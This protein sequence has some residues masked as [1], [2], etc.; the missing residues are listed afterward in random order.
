LEEFN[1]HYISPELQSPFDHASLSVSVTIKEEHI[2][3]RKQTI[4]KNSKEKKNFIEELKNMMSNIDTS[5]IFNK[6]GFFKSAIYYTGCDSKP[7]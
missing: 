4:V 6:K 5:N 7:W 2:Q 3:E 1:N